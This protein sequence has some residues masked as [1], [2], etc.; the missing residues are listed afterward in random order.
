MTT[1]LITNAHNR[2]LPCST[3]NRPLFCYFELTAVGGGEGG[4]GGGGGGGGFKIV[5]TKML[6][7]NED[8]CIV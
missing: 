6:Q 4:G 8:M 2:S 3:L 7:N 5:N 1:Y